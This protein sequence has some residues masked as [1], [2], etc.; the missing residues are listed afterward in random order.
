MKLQAMAVGCVLLSLATACGDSKSNAPGP[1][2][3]E[4]GAG[5]NGAGAGAGSGA[6]DTGGSS[7]SSGSNQGG[8]NPGESAGESAGGAAAGSAG[9][10]GADAFG[11]SKDRL[12]VG[13]RFCAINQEQ[14]LVCWEDEP[15]TRPG[16]FIG[17]HIN[18]DAMCTLRASGEATCLGAGNPPEGERFIAVRTMPTRACGQRADKT[19]LCWGEESSGNVSAV[20]KS[21]VDDFALSL[22]TCA[23]SA[24]AA[25]DC[26][27]PAPLAP[28][29]QV[30]LK[31]LVGSYYF[32]CGIGLDATIHC[33]GDEPYAP[34]TPGFT[35]AAMVDYLGDAW[36]CALTTNNSLACWG[37]APITQEQRQGLQVADFAIGQEAICVVLADRSVKC[38]GGPEAPTDLRVY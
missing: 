6:V 29:P 11:T 24:G 32:V 8:A 5:G 15:L 14:D 9:A 2:A 22:L 7:A 37:N 1:S 38:F 23:T 19:V 33:W 30:E 20:T 31:Q 17:V 18:Q 10:A 27:G 35:K 4:S 21:P 34:A 36:G 25:P 13:S 26:W 16:P 28:P 3:G 12:G